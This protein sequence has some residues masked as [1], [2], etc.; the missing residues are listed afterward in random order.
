MRPHFHA[1]V[2]FLLRLISWYIRT[3]PFAL[4]KGFLMWK[5]VHPLLPRS[6]A[7]FVHEL[8]QG[9]KVLLQYSEVVGTTALLTR[10]WE[11]AETKAL[12]RSAIPGSTAIDIG[13]NVGLVTVAL[14]RAVGPAGRVLAVE[15][16][17]ENVRRLIANINLNNLRNVEIFP[18]ALAE[19][20]R[21]VSLKIGADPAVH[22][23]TNVFQGWKTE[24]AV[25]VETRT[26]DECWIEA[27]RPVVSVIKI[28]VE[29]V[30][31]AV[32]RGGERL[33]ARD[34]PTM[35]IEIADSQSLTALQV[36]LEKF[37]YSWTQP[38]GFERWNYLFHAASHE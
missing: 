14:A 24:D 11:E 21:E 18:F 1:M 12:C 10:R 31:L 26:L 27:G 25:S 28:D 17:P 16:F 37:G 30:E 7:S 4:G 15:P 38:H 13:A 29:G 34:Q 9:G 20:R 23:I 3:S 6:P 36:H 19:Q 5:L 35:M 8:P 33:L 32:L 2:W 22:S